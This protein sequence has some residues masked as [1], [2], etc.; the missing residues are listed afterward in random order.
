MKNSNS[1][2]KCCFITAKEA[3]T[4]LVC[5]SFFVVSVLF[6][7]FYYPWPYSAQIPENIKTVVLDLDQSSISRRLV[8]ELQASPELHLIAVLDELAPAKNILNQEKAKALITIPKNFASDFLTNR[9]TSISLVANG[10]FIVI[11]RTTM[12][13]AQGPVQTA[14]QNALTKEMVDGGIPL[15]K[16]VQASK[17]PPP[18]TVQYMYNTIAGYQ[19]FIVPI[20]FTII[21]QTAF[22]AGIGLLIHDWFIRKKAPL[23]LLEAIRG[24]KGYSALLLTFTLLIFTWIVFLEGISFWWHEIRSFQNIYATLLT[25]VIY[26]FSIAT[27]GICIAF[28]MGKTPL[29]V[30]LSVLSSIGAIFLTG[31]IFPWENMP[32]WAH[33]LAYCLPSTPATSALLQSSQVGAPISAITP[34]LIHLVLLST[35]F[36]CL[37]LW[38]ASRYQIQ[39]R[40]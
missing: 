27:L 39:Y 22:I 31:N 13:G 21:F 35:F 3:L 5:M 23:P 32:T 38:Q 25:S 37:G 40:K 17:A 1:F 33:A 2:I 8:Q 6:Y 24:I 20:V 29:V 16:V 11:S 28:F 26:A 7:S 19:N 14:I 4:N 18:L 15:S 9:P 10:S 36:L 30:Q 12:K 34:Y